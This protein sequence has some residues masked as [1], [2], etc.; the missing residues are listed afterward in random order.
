MPRDPGQHRQAMRRRPTAS[1][2]VTVVVLGGAVLFI[3]S[4]LQPHLLVA[5][6]TPAGGDMGAHVWGPAYMR[7]H[8]LPHFRLSG[9]APSWYDGFPPFQFYF[10]LPSLVIVLLDVLLPIPYGVAF[11]VVTILGLLSLPVCAWA[12]GRLS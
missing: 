1:A 3:L 10:P 12:F 5:N 11:K 9:W 7:D 4:Q 2:L 6:T 8:L